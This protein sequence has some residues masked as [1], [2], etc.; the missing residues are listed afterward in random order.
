[1]AV[2]VHRF[3][4]LESVM[5][6]IA[7]FRSKC[8]VESVMY[9]SLCMQGC[10]ILDVLKKCTCDNKKCTCDN[11]SSPINHDHESGQHYMN[12]CL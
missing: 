1:M 7:I 5:K 4:T 3:C 11:K 8:T 2:F 6:K 9:K 12:K 10:A